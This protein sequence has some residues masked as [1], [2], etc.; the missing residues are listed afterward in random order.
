MKPLKI[1]PVEEGNKMD[2][3]FIDECAPF[4]K[5]LKIFDPGIFK[6]LK[7]NSVIVKEGRIRKMWFK[8][9]AE[10]PFNYFTFMASSAQEKHVIQVVTFELVQDASDLTFFYYIA[11][12]MIQKLVV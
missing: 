1:Y 11:K 8:I 12:E 3:K 4:I 9:V 10:E 6:R 2:Q 5:A 7:V